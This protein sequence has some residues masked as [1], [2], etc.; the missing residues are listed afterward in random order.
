MQIC[1]HGLTARN[2][3][4]YLAQCKL[5]ELFTCYWGSQQCAGSLKLFH[6]TLRTNILPLAHSDTVQLQDLLISVRQTA[7][8]AC[9]KT[10]YT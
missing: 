6:E 7:N 9:K 3:V 4:T 8:T 1:A 2:N 10:D 5:S